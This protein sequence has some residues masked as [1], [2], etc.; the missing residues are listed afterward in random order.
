MN[1]TLKPDFCCFPRG[2]SGLLGIEAL[3]EGLIPPLPISPF[4][5]KVSPA[6]LNK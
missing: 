1:T 3:P 5:D 4:L 2:L 6:V